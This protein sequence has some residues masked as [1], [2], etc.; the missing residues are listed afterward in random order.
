[1][2]VYP[3]IEAENAAD[4]GNVKRACILLKVSRAAYYAHRTTVVSARKREDATLTEEIIAIHDESKGTYGAPRSHAELRAR[5]RRHSRKRVARLLRA[6][7]R[8]GRSPKRWRTTT[9]PDPCPTTPR[10]GNLAVRTAA[11]STRTAPP[12]SDRPIVTRPSRQQP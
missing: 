6:A 7:G 3:F 5:G 4:S 10:T 9:V 11:S 2:N 8:V 1:V 12:P